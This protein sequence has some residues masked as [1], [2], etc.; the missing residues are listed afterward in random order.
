M[1]KCSKI[2]Q[3]PGFMCRDLNVARYGKTLGSCA[4]TFSPMQMKAPF[5]D[6]NTLAVT[7]IKYSQKSHDAYSI[8]QKM[9]TFIKTNRIYLYCPVVTEKSTYPSVKLT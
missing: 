5:T 4:E 9:I 7:I 6:V 2:L 1:D 8:E 3:N